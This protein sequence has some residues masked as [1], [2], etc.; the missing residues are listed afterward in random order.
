[1]CK[2]KLGYKNSILIYVA[3]TTCDAS[4]IDYDTWPVVEMCSSEGIRTFDCSLKGSVI[5]CIL[6]DAVEELA[7]NFLK[8]F[9][10][11]YY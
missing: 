6:T 8:I 5:S 2:V 1:M 3:L 11:T 4:V 10:M 7:C 9:V